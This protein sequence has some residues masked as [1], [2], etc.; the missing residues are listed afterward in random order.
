[1]RWHVNVSALRLF[2]MS[3]TSSPLGTTCGFTHAGDHAMRADRSSELET[4]SR[5]R[6][7]LLASVATVTGVIMLAGLGDLP[8]L[9]QMPAFAAAHAAEAAGPIGFADIVQKV[10]PAG[11][12]VRVKLKSESPSVSS[13]DNGGKENQLPFPKGSPFERFFRGFG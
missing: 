1:M 3:E 13:N 6:L 7:A 5:R 4:F 9:G 11:F 2:L 8:P 12:F 10:K